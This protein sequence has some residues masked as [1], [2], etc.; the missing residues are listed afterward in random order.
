[1]RNDLKRLKERKNKN[2][3]YVFKKQKNGVL[4]TKIIWSQCLPRLFS[5]LTFSFFVFNLLMSIK[6]N[7]QHHKML[8]SLIN[9]V[10][11]AWVII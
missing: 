9:E 10:V 1:M 7:C 8:S 11:E 5:K 4:N 3:R 6:M 2:R